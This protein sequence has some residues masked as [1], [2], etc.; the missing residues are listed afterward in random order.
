MLYNGN[1]V[2]RMNRAEFHITHNNTAFSAWNW[3]AI[4][5]YIN[6][7]IIFIF[8]FASKNLSHIYPTCNIYCLV[9]RSGRNGATGAHARYRAA[10]AEAGKDLEI[11]VEIFLNNV[12]KSTPVKWSLVQAKESVLHGRSGLHG[13]SVPTPVVMETSRGF[14][15]V[16]QPH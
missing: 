1:A 15:L 7:L 14:N 2:S 10:A 8:H 5:L 9:A 13:L 3:N 16:P 11:V 6:G 12:T 4:K